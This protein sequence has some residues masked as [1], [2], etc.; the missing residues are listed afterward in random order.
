MDIFKSAYYHKCAVIFHDRFM[1]LWL[2][3]SQR[4]EFNK[5]FK[6]KLKKTHTMNFVGQITCMDV[7]YQQNSYTNKYRVDDDNVTSSL[8][9]Y[10]ETI[11]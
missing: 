4:I 5:S 9:Y 8:T 7:M 11:P 2:G 10:I 1:S 6:S 3:Q